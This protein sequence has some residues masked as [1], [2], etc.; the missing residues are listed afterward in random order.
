MN[1]PTVY[2]KHLQGKHIVI[3]L[4]YASKQRSFMVAAFYCETR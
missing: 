4:I 1:T 3:I 2:L